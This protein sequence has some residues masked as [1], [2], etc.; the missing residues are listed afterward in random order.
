MVN[1]LERASAD[2]ECAMARSALF[3]LFVAIVNDFEGA[4]ES[5]F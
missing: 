3:F 1:E 5:F 4:E 2:G